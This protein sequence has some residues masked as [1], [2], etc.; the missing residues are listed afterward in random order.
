MLLQILSTS[1]NFT[2][3]EEQYFADGAQKAY[4]SFTK[5]AA[6]S[7]NMTVENLR[8]LAQGRVWTGRQAFNRG[9]VDHIG[10]LWLGLNI[11]LNM[12]GI[13]TSKTNRIPVQTFREPRS[14]PSLPFGSRS[15]ATSISATHIPVYS[16]CDD[17]ISSSNLGSL[18]SFGLTNDLNRIGVGPLTAALLRQYTV[19]SEN[20]ISFLSS[21]L[22]EIAM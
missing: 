8:E 1:R 19:N 21:T 3:E 22:K 10:G 4:N 13:D 9:L 12:S 5:K 15:S 20:I 17:I 16:I 14:G 18:E 2:T 6:F 11:A 7:R